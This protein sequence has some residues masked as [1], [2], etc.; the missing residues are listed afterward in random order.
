MQASTALNNKIE[1][2][3]SRLNS[4]IALKITRQID[5]AHNL[6]LQRGYPTRAYTKSG[7]ET[8]M[9]FDESKQLQVLDNTKKLLGILNSIEPE[10]EPGVDIEEIVDEVAL[11]KKALSCFGFTVKD[12]TWEQ[13][14]QNRIIEIYNHQGVQLHRSLN[15]FKT[16]GYSLL[17]LCVNEWYVLWER[18]SKVMAQLNEIVGQVM[19]GASRP[20]TE[21]P[22]GPHVVRETYDDG[23]TQPFLPRSIVVQFRDMYPTFNALDEIC[24]FIVTSEA[25]L[26]SVGDEALKLD[27]I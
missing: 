13:K 1:T 8:L 4:A 12:K 5:H 15:F 18:P 16:C 17:D 14:A 10:P 27:F 25:R 26:L 20:S 19:S 11:A 24:G 2:D 3:A 9:G 22:V 7:V 21:M 23:T 6:L